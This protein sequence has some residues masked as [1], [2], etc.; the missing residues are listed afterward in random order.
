MDTRNQARV[1]KSNELPCRLAEPSDEKMN[2]GL[3]TPAL[4]ARTVRQTGH[5][6]IANELLEAITRHP[7]K[8]TA[9][10]VLLALIRKT[11]GFN[12]Q[13]DDLSASQL[14]ALLGTMRRQHITTVLNELAL[15]RVIHKR[16]GRYGSVVGINKDHSQWLARPDRG[17]ANADET[18]GALQYPEESRRGQQG[19][20]LALWP[21]EHC[22]ESPAVSTLPLADGSEHAARADQ[23]LQWCAAFPGVDVP[24]EFRRMRAW[25]DANKALLKTSRGIDRFIVSWLGRAQ[26]DA[27]KPQYV[28]PNREGNSQKGLIH[29]NFNAQDY[30]AGVSED[31]R[32]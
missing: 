6:Q 13:E 17:Q 14:G 23:V 9:L 22:G 19:A 2:N 18:K 12:K 7:F 27:V 20:E 32:F 25:L 15:M 1:P 4:A 28:R 31:G 21:S 16:P 10:R 29:G 30:R 24:G 5:T 11:I 26:R 3:E 8:Q